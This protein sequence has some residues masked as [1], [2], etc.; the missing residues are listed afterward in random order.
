VFFCR[1][2]YHYLCSTVLLTFD[3]AY[4]ANHDMPL[5]TRVFETA[6]EAFEVEMNDL[7]EFLS[8]RR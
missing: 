6:D 3:R 1:F 8:S 5:I 4:Q 2:Y 7:D